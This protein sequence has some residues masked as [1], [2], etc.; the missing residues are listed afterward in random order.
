MNPPYDKL[1]WNH[2]MSG[3][4][5]IQLRFASLR[6]GGRPIQIVRPGCGSPRGAGA[7]RRRLHLRFRSLRRSL[8]ASLAPRRRTEPGRASAAPGSRFGAPGCTANADG[9]AVILN[10][11]LDRV[12]IRKPDGGDQEPGP[13]CVACLRTEEPVLRFLP[14]LARGHDARCLLRCRRHRTAN[15]QDRCAC[16]YSRTGARSQPAYGLYLSR[17]G[18]SRCGDASGIRGPPCR[19]RVDLSPV[20]RGSRHFGTS[21]PLFLGPS[22]KCP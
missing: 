10:F 6:P 15:D 4:F 9:L 19:V 20:A 13:A 18:Q 14:R 5:G 11:T 21:D 17:R 1:S 2:R 7:T 12:S 8:R 3:Q 22:P 16:R